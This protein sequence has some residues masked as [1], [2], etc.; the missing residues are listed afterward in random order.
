MLSANKKPTR[1]AALTALAAAPLAAGLP[2]V[3]EA[4]E[5]DPIFA[6]IERHRE[7]S[8]SYTA[9]VDVSSDL[10]AGPEFKAADAITAERC[11][12]L[13]DHAGTLVR[14]EPTTLTGVAALVRYVA[15]LEEWQT[16]VDRDLEAFPIADWHQAFLTTLA[17]ALDKISAVG[18]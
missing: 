7:L 13:L 5:P 9:A 11:Q 12:A 17:N 6:A 4:A 2:A 15:S 14:S 18:V 3:T 1:R 10:K 16:P 8:E